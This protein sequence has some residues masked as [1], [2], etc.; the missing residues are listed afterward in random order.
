MDLK[1]NEKLAVLVFI[2][3]G[4]YAS[5]SAGNQFGP[6]FLIEQRVILVTLNYRL[7]I[8]GFMSLGT[9]EYSGNMGLKDQ[10]LA[11]KW[12]HSNIEHFSGDNQR[13]TLFGHSAGGSSTNFQILSSESRSYFRNAIPMSGSVDD[14]WAMYKE[15]DHLALA[16]KIAKDIGKPINSLEELI[17]VLKVA[18]AN[19]LSEYS[20]TTGFLRRTFTTEFA[21]LVESESDGHNLHLHG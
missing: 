19:K 10:Q 16:Y 15:N 2:H 14:F 8:L 9:P 5:G 20:V 4:A 11:L 13:I 6:D 17:E 1:S 7:G 18:P 12:V 3:G 21:P